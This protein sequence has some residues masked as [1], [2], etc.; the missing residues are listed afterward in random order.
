MSRRWGRRIALHAGWLLLMTLGATL[1]HA[2]SKD[3]A[4]RRPACPAPDDT[5]P[6]PRRG[7]YLGK[8]HCIECHGSEAKLIRGGA[9]APVVA[10]ADLLGC[11][12][13]HGPGALHGK[14]A[15]NDPALITFPP[16]L[17]PENQRVL[18]G[19]CHAPEIAGHGGDP[20]GFAMAR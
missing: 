6:F 2:R 20:A 9:H 14:D 15:D 18:C 12:T 4:D 17:S 7:E 5:A 3:A 1:F 8:E 13:C 11:E 19:R 16:V 10:H